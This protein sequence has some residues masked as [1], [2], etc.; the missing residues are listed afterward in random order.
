MQHLSVRK[1]H[2]SVRLVHPLLMLSKTTDYCQ[3]F[4]LAL[5]TLAETFWVQAQS[6][7]SP[8]SRTTTARSRSRRA[9]I[10]SRPPQAI[11]SYWLILSTIPMSVS[12][13]LYAISTRW[14]ISGFFALRRCTRRRSRSRSRLPGLSI[15]PR[16]LLPPLAQQVRRALG[17]RAHPRPP[18]RPLTRPAEPAQPS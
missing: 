7:L 13:S 15:Q 9:R 18:P 4:P 1:L 17:P 12:P 8:S 3:I 14:L 16:T 2:S 6:R 10:S 11:P 5:R